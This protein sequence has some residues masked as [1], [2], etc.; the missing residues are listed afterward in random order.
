MIVIIFL[1]CLNKYIKLFRHWSP[2]FIIHTWSWELW[3]KSMSCA[4]YLAFTQCFTASHQQ[5][6]PK[7]VI[8][9]SVSLSA[10]Q[11]AHTVWMSHVSHLRLHSYP[12]LCAKVPL[13]SLHFACKQPD[14]LVTF[15]K[16]S[17][18]IV[19]LAF[20]RSFKNFLWTS[21]ALFLLILV[22]LF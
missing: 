13:I 22:H 17:W 12:Q 20:W 1:N 16:R 15:L 7:V 14:A 6:A 21:A 10:D 19:F 11:S 2:M 4:K 5:R 8:F 3:E 9:I 18:S